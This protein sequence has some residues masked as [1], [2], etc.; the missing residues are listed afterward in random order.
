MNWLAREGVEPL[1]G[2][3]SMYRCLVRH[4]LIDPKQ[5]ARRRRRTTSGGSGPGRWSCGR[6][7]SSAGCGSS[8]AARR[9]SCPASMTTPGSVCRPGWWRGRR[10]GRCVTRWRRRCGRHG[11]PEEILTDNGKVF[12]GRF[13]PGPGRCCSTGSA[14]RTASAICSPRRGRR[15]RRARS[16]GGTRRCAASSSTARSFDTIDDAQAALD[17]W[18]EHYNHERPHQSL[19]DRPP[20]ERFRLARAELLEP[21]DAEP[22]STTDADE[23]VPSTP[24]VTGRR[25]HRPDQPGRSPL[26]RRALAGRSRPSRSSATAGSSRSLHAVCSSP[27]TPGATRRRRSRW[28]CAARADRPPRRRAVGGRDPQGRQQRLVSFAGTSYRVGNTYR[29]RQVQV[30][31]VGDTVQISFEGA[32]RANP[33]HPP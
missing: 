9:R 6:W 10:R 12:T 20:I 21:V 1:P 23:V 17:A 29:R 7:T 15:P 18:V 22:E 2:R 24:R 3:S 11:V 5:A 28:C 25:R 33:S 32:A 27:P 19:G 4:G 13:G 26:P 30:A 16:S 8:T 14:G 31:V